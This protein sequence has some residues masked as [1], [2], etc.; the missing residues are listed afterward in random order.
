MADSR[1]FRYKNTQMAYKV[2]GEGK[3]LIILHGWGVSGRVMVPLARHLSDLRTCYV[4]DLPG[5]GESPEPPE[6]WEID[7]YADLIEVFIN[8]DE[9]ATGSVDLLAHSFGGRI[10]LKLCSRKQASQTIDKVLITGGAGMTPRRSFSYYVKS[11]TAKVLKAPFVIL[12]SAMQKK[13]LSWLRNTTLWKSLGSSDYQKLSGVMRQTFVKSVSEHLEPC[14][15]NIEHEILLLWGEDDE[16]TPLYQAK[17]ME[18][19]LENAAL[20]TIKEAGHYAFLDRRRK[21]NSITRAFFT[22]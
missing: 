9:T 7:E 3:P 4:V 18:E 6:P 17:R 11:Y 14:L 2:Y 15:P 21:F 10:T 19:G 8:S 5:F 12:P 13:A 22:A 16:A 1:V 20:V